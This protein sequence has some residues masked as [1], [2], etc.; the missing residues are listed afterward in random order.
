M[1]S[2]GLGT[3]DF[4]AYHTPVPKIQGFDVRLTELRKNLA[5]ILRDVRVGVSPLDSMVEASIHCQEAIAGKVSEFDVLR[6]L[7]KLGERCELTKAGPDIVL[8]SQGALKAEVKER[9]ENTLQQVLRLS[10]AQDEDPSKAVN[11]PAEAL[12]RLAAWVTYGSVRKAMDMQKADILFCD[13]SRTLAG[14]MLPIAEHFWGLQMGFDEAYK[15]AVRTAQAGKSAI[16]VVV[17]A[18]GLNP[19]LRALSLTREDVDALGKP[20]WDANKS[21]GLG[22]YDLTVLLSEVLKP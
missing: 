15:N 19:K 13:V 9:H 14:A 16:V 4:S 20:L 6:H 5:G 17:S 7:L 18:A 12:S 2:G 3:K 11:M 21:L 1:L 22:S 8:L 10:A